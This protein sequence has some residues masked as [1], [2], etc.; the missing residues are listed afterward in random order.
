VNLLTCGFFDKA[1]AWD[2]ISIPP[3]RTAVLKLTMAPR[4]SKCSLIWM[5]SSLVGDMTQ[6]KKGY[7][8]SRSL[9]MT[10]IAKAAVL[11]LPVSASPMISLPDIKF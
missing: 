8:F 11:P 7:G 3:T 9:W 2:I 5:Q 6:A 10:G 1:I 4:A